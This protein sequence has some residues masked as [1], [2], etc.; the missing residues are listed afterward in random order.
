[1]DLVSS[2][3]KKNAQANPLDLA[4]PLSRPLQFRCLCFWRGLALLLGDGLAIAERKGTQLADAGCQQLIKEADP[5]PKNI[6]IA[7]MT[8]RGTLAPHCM[9][10]LTQ[11]SPCFPH[12]R[13]DSMLDASPTCDSADGCFIENSTQTTRMV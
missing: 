8:I 4:S 2:S 3:P 11:I 5:H 13:Q 9:K 7:T 6:A 10:H 12:R 1:M